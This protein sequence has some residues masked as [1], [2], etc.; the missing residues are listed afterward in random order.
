MKLQDCFFVRST[1]ADLT[2]TERENFDGNRYV[3]CYALYI[4]VDLKDYGPLRIAGTTVDI[5]DM[6]LIR[7]WEAPYS[8]SNDK[9]GQFRVGPI[10]SLDPQDFR[11]NVNAENFMI[12]PRDKQGLIDEYN[13]AIEAAEEIDKRIGWM[14]AR[15]EKQFSEK[16]YKTEEIILAL[17]CGLS[18]EN[19]D[20]LKDLLK[21][22][23][24]I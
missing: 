14:E 4:P 21:I 18:E 6:V 22:N 20:K 10:H 11:N 17:D 16:D 12:I 7:S 24:K 19:E 5:G 3:G 15:G 8:Y 9:L 2:Q 13:K 23:I 1:L